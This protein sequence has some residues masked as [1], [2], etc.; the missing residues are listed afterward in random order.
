MDLMDDDYA[1]QARFQLPVSVGMRYGTLPEGVAEARTVPAERIRISTNVYMKGAI[2]SMTSPSHPTL[3]LQPDGAH[4]TTPCVHRKVGEY[5]SS[6]FL[7]EDFVLSIKADGLDAA[8]CF[9][10]R[11][12]TGTIAMQF[13]VV[14]QFK[15]PP[16]SEQ[17]YI[18]LVD[19][20]GSMGGN[21]I[22]MAKRALVMLLRALPRRGT[23][24][25]IFSFGSACSSLWDESKPYNAQTLQEAV[26][27]HYTMTL[28]DH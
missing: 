28:S 12:A 7:S 17:E 4:E 9:A 18:F 6:S 11:S 19:R 22:D 24:F 10:Q 21:R 20:S 2:L 13:T 27:R 16:I 23:T 8:R 25:N 3:T 26:S 15:L 14:P 5:R 1:D